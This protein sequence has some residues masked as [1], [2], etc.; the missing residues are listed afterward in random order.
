MSGTR[1]ACIDIGSNTTALLVADVTGDGQLSCVESD[2]IFTLL[3]ADVGPTGISE[4]KIAEVVD[5]VTTLTD[6]AESLGCTTVE[7]VATHVVREAHNGNDLAT[8]AESATGRR[9]RVIDGHEE[10][11]YALIGA[12]GGLSRLRATTVVIDSGGGSTEV[13]WCAPGGEPVTASFAL[14]SALLQQQFIESDP[15]LPAE[16]KRA[17]AF[18]AEQFERLEL[19]DAIALALVVGGGASTA[20]E[21]TGGVLDKAGIARVLAIAMSSDSAAIAERFK[22][23]PS[24]AQLLAASLT[25]LDVLVDRIG[26]DLEVGRGGLREGVLLDTPT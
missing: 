5:A 10:A 23:A 4:A 16:L 1:R 8:A 18:A 11:R 26:I 25:I 9:L 13:S 24:R 14:G 7:I 2:R 15:P 12:V 21:L 20:R 22:L 3:A 6:R 17:R 19:P